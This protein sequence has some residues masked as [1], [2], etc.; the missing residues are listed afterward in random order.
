MPFPL[1]IPLITAGVSAL[2]GALS[3]KKSART[4]EQSNRSTS[5]STTSFSEPA[6]YKTLGDL[7][8]S[9]IESRLRSTMDMGGYEAGGVGAINDSFAGAQTALDADL[10]SRGLATSP[11]AGAA[12]GNLQSER[13]TN[14]AQFLNTLPQLKRQMEGEDLSAA[15]TFYQSRPR[16]ST[17]TQ[18]G[19]QSGTTIMPGSV[20]GGAFGS[21]AEMIAFLAGQGLLGGGAYPN[22][23]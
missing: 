23:H 1:L 6:E 10:T 5:T 19:T 22:I 15:N 8:R 7:L 16:N 20:A 11:I 3:N 12:G 13:G 9:R 21:A 17:T 2:G 14:I 4:Q 18:T